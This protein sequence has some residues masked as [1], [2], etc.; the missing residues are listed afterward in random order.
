LKSKYPKPSV[1]VLI[2]VYQSSLSGAERLSLQQGM[3]ILANYPV[4]IVK[5][6]SLNIDELKEHFPNLEFV[7]FEDKYFKGTAG[8]NQLLTSVHFYKEFTAYDYILIYQLDAFV[9]RDELA[10]WCVRGF[11]YIGAPTLHPDEFDA[12]PAESAQFY[13]DSLSKRRFVLNGG[14]SLRKVQS[15]IRYL[16][17]YNLFYPAWTG[18]EDM[19][20]SQEA[21]RL[22]PMKLFMKLPSWREA[23]H[24]AFEKSP[25]ASFKLTEENLPFACHAWERYDPEFWKVYISENQGDALFN[26]F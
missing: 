7:S 22:I 11:D 15:F 3:E 25:A 13:S 14:L 6:Q 1:A 23:M 21:T 5:P 18:N 24:F 26:K 19:L 20:F 4:K 12:L 8:Y 16:K 17:I 2:P 10:A 9:F